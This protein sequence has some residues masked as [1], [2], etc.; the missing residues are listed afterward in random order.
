TVR[1]VMLK[2]K[3]VGMRKVRYLA[4]ALVLA[5]SLTVL[6]LDD[7][8]LGDDGVQCIAQALTNSKVTY[9]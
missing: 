3:C 5:K 4:K 1:D 6:D 9:F 8:K 2:S 7:N